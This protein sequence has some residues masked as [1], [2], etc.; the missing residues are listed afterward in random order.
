VFGDGLVTTKSLPGHT[1]GHQGLLV[2]LPQTGPVLLAGDVAYSA[3]DY[4]RTA[5]RSGNVDLEASRH[6]IERAKTI[7]RE[8]RAT[9]WLHHD[10]EAQ[11]AVSTAPSADR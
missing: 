4:A 1:P 2:M 11:A 9:V 10:I 6:S 5:V 7:E 3:S 8:L